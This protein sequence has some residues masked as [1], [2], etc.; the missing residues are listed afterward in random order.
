RPAGA[1]QPSLLQLGASPPPET[2]AQWFETVIAVQRA[3]ADSPAFYGQTARALVD[4]VGLDQGLV[5]LRRGKAWEVVARAPEQGGRPGQ[6]FSDTILRRV[7]AE[8][9]TFYQVA[10]KTAPSE[11]LQGVQAVVASPVFGAGG[12]VAGVL[13][14]SRARQPQGRDI[15]PLEAQVVQL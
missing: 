2:L 3:A 6:D 15:G 12:R 14:G 5:L 7:V 1:P 8:R 10:P 11:S 4:L 9:R 13:Y